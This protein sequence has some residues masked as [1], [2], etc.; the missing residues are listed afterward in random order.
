VHLL[1]G[2]I[3]LAKKFVGENGGHSKEHDEFYKIVGVSREQ[4]WIQKKSTR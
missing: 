3:E 2:K 4:V 1:P